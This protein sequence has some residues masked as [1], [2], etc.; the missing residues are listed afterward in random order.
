[1]PTNSVSNT[2]VSNTTQNTNNISTNNNSTLKANTVSSNTLTSST[3]TSKTDI[4]KELFTNNVLK[5]DSNNKDY[6]I[7]NINIESNDLNGESFK[8]LYPDS[9]PNDIFAIVK[10][11]IKPFDIDAG[12]A[13]NGEK[14]GDWVVNK[15][16]CVYIKYNNGNYTIKNVGTGW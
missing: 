14:Q 8:S 7:D 11:S 2:Y 12:L 9:T 4:V 15:S 3:D 5:N 13:G 16:N 10:Y 6:R 1:M